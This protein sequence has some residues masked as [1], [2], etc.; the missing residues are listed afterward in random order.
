MRIYPIYQLEGTHWYVLFLKTKREKSKTN[1]E[2]DA[3]KY[4]HEMGINYEFGSETLHVDKEE[5][6]GNIFI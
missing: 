4:F 2:K 3:V 1:P 6:V 5:K